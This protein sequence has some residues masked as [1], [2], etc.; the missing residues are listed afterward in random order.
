MHILYLHQ[1]FATRKGSTGTR[2]YEFAR[3]WVA[4]GHRVTVLTSLAQLTESDVRVRPW[5]L[6]T[7][8]E[9]DGIDVVALH[10]K[11]RQRMGFLRRVWA[12]F[13]FT[14]LATWFVVCRRG[15]DVVYATSTPLTVGIPPLVARFLRGRRYVFEVRDA[16][17]AVPVALGLIRSTIT[18]AAL[19][20]LERAIYRRAEAIV[21]L[22]PGMASVVRAAAP[23]AQRI[24]TIPNCADTELFHPDVDGTPTRRRYGWNGRIVCIHAGAMGRVN[25]LD[26]VVRAADHFR[27]DAEL[28]FVLLGEGSEKEW[29]R[30][31]CERLGLA[32]LDILD[33]VTKRDLPAVLAAADVGLMT[34]VDVPLLE[35]N[36]ANKLFDYLSMGKPVV[37]NYGGWQRDVLEG[38]GAG[39]GSTM[40]DE[41]NF[42]ENIASLKADPARRESMGQ[43]ARRLATDTYDRDRL[44]ARALEIIIDCVK[45]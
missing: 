8:F 10:V 11:Y 38:A 42:F 3:R 29:L 21:T 28:L 34:I 27:D 6:V 18:I 5:R 24:E 25:G 16:W 13:C 41:R 33:A 44:A 36:S 14:A 9:V 37:L 32:N 20:R 23:S 1:Y 7:R 12:F 30:R 19:R 39:L 35:H 43:A 45:R 15:V 4:A 31:Q 26:A 40:G 2:S 17:P 22:S